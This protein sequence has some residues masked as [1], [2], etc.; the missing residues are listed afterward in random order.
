VGGEGELRLKRSW[1]PLM[2]IARQGAWKW[3]QGT[4]KAYWEW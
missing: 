1:R 4:R 3:Y 2:S